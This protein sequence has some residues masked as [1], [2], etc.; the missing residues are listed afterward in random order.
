MK[1]LDFDLR[2]QAMKR[3]NLI[4]FAVLSILLISPVTTW[5][6][7]P[8]GQQENDRTGACE[9]IPGWTK[10]SK[11]TSA[12]KIKL[13]SYDIKSSL[14][15]TAPKW[16]NNPIKVEATWSFPSEGIQPYPLVIYLLSS[17]GYSSGYDGKWIKWFNNQGFAT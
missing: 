7:C 10:S 12:K 14:P 1:R 16:K 17:G 9:P 3:A 6:G 8:E 5:A 2:R 15:S 4:A 11:E 13:E